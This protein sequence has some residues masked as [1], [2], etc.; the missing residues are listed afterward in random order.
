MLRRPLYLNTDKDERFPSTIA[1]CIEELTQKFSWYRSTYR[2]TANH[3]KNVD[4]IND[5]VFLRSISTRGS[6]GSTGECINT[7]APDGSWY[8]EQFIKRSA[9]EKW[10]F[11]R[12][13]PPRLIFILVKNRASKTK[14][15]KFCG[16]Y[17]IAPESTATMRVYKR[18]STE[19]NRYKPNY[20][21]EED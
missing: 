21:N 11:D 13:L 18:I 10:E 19:Y 9:L 1:K 15:F 4:G 8:T 2:N 12:E 5:V 3:F 7:I 6:T 17:R 14:Y 20:Y 16:I